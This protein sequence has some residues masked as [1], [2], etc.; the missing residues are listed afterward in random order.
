MHGD[1]YKA[2]II[3]KLEKFRKCTNGVTILMP[4]LPMFDYL[5]NRKVY[6]KRSIGCKIDVLYNFCS[7][8]YLLLQFLT[9]NSPKELVS[10]SS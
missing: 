10:L 3:I 8:H 2:R 1:H 9:A 5:E 7:K 6:R 4:S